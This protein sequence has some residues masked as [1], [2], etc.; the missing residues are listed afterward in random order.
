[1]FAVQVSIAQPDDEED[2]SNYGTEEGVKRFCTP[3]VVGLSPQRLI[4]IGYEFAGPHSINAAG[5]GAFAAQSGEVNNYMGLNISAN[6][7]VI[8]THKFLLNLGMNYVGSNYSFKNDALTNPFLQSLNGNI[9]TFGLNATIF[10]PLNEKN[11]L[12]GFVSGD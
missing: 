12:L 3:K 8:A 6:L 4:S 1:M 7:P 2:Y 5:L 9:R 10:K 11:Y